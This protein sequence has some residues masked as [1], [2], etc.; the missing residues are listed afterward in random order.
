MLAIGFGVWCVPVFGYFF[1]CI[2][3]VGVIGVGGGVGGAGIDHAFRDLDERSEGA[4][5]AEDSG[6][7]E[8]GGPV[9]GVEERRCGGG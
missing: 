3:F 8:E 4:T 9:R 6:P 2:V 7:G 1:C 5:G